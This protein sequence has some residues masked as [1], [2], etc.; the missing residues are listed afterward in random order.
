MTFIYL[1]I[2]RCLFPQSGLQL[3]QIFY[4]IMCSLFAFAVIKL[5]RKSVYDGLRAYKCASIYAEPV[6]IND[7]VY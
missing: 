4:V 2:F 5:T 1:E 3:R 7:N 6:K